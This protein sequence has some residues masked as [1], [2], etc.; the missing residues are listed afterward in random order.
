[1]KLFEWNQINWTELNCNNIER[2]QCANRTRSK[3]VLDGVHDML[4]LFG[5]PGMLHF[6]T[7]HAVFSP[8]HWPEGP[9]APF[10]PAGP[11]PP[12]H[13]LSPGC[14]S[15]PLGPVPPTVPRWPRSPVAPGRPGSPRG[16]CSPAGPRAPASPVAPALPLRPCWPGRPGCPKHSTGQIQ[17][18]ILQSMKQ[19]VYRSITH[20]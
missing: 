6:F 3:N 8:T 13:P 15:W 14:P 11:V 18:S 5:P 17:R 19:S 16:P 7:H 4:S 1:M 9:M 20:F 2:A 10:D 12:V